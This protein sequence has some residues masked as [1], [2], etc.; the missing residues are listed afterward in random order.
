MASKIPHRLEEV[1]SVAN[2]YTALQLVT[3]FFFHSVEIPKCEAVK[4]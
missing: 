3:D 4:W 1:A 2:D